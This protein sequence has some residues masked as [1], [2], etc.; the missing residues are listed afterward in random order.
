LLKS[1]IK[2]GVTLQCRKR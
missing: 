1:N 2:L